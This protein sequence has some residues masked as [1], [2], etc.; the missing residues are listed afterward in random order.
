MVWWVTFCFACLLCAA[1]LSTACT[2]KR[3]V[4][5]GN[6][7]CAFRCAVRQV[8]GQERQEERKRLEIASRVGCREQKCPHCCIFSRWSADETCGSR[9]P[10]R[11]C[12]ERGLTASLVVRFRH[13]FPL[14]QHVKANRMTNLTGTGV[15]DDLQDGGEGKVSRNKLTTTMRVWTRCQASGE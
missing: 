8:V 6:F 10:T 4:Q 11:F 9:H 5:G 7:L 12:F 2:K 14:Y 1:A 15:Q 3:R 13:H